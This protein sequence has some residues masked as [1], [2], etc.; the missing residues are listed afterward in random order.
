MSEASQREAQR[1]RAAKNQSLFREVNERIEDLSVNAAYSSFICECM[2]EGC[3]ESV[4]MTVE[5]Y[6]HVRASS[7]QFLVLPGHNVEAVEHVIE[8]N[9]RFLIVAK[10]GAGAAV[11]AQLDPRDRDRGSD[12]PGFGSTVSGDGG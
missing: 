5:E 1:K 10:L 11:A 7:N 9:E 6:E 4:S 3:N 8:G 12:P 2:D